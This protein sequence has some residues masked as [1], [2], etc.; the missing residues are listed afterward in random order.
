MRLQQP[1]KNI[2]DGF[3]RTHWHGTH[4]NSFAALRFC[5][6]AVERAG[7]VVDPLFF[8][9]AVGKHQFQ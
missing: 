4:E 7:N 1:T 3:S 8:L 6:A 2:I 9:G 5:T